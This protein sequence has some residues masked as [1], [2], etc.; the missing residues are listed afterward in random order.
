MA[1][2][3]PMEVNVTLEYGDLTE[4]QWKSIVRK[5]EDVVYDF[6]YHIAWDGWCDC[7]DGC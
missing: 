7:Y 1:F 4:D 3:Q 6:A 5:I 2:E